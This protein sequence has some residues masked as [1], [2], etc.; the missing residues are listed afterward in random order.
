LKI[1]VYSENYSILC[2]IRRFESQIAG[3]LKMQ[4]KRWT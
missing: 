3:D 1:L 2:F 4:L